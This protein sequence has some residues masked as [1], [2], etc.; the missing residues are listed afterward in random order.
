MSS[1]IPRAKV[2]SRAL[3]LALAV[4]LSGCAA[5]SALHMG[6]EAEYQQDYDRAVVEYT[7]ALRLKPGDADARAGLERAKV[8]ASEAHLQRAR[9]LS[10]T[11]KLDEALVEYQIAAELNPANGDIEKELRATRAQL[12]AKVV[13]SAEGKTRLETLIEVRKAWTEARNVKAFTAWLENAIEDA[14]KPRFHSDRPENDA[15]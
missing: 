10:A 15:A 13:V 5:S 6:Q 4:A 1:L 3:P 9:R 2:V 11:G 14:L 12:R 8:R 7:K